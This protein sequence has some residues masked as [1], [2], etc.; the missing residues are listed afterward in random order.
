MDSNEIDRI[1]ASMGLLPLVEPHFAKALEEKQNLEE[2]IDKLPDTDTDT[3]FVEGPSD[4]LLLKTAL[5]LF[6]PEGTRCIN[7][8]CAPKFGGGHSWVADQMIAWAYLR[9]QSRA[10]GLFDQ[11]QCA[12][13]SRKR[14]THTIGNNK[15]QKTYCIHLEPNENVKSIL[16]KIK[17]PFA[18][19]ELFRDT[20]W[21]TAENNGWLTE[22]SDNLPGLYGHND[23]NSSFLDTL[24][25]KFP[26]YP[27]RRIV[28]YKIRGDSKKQFVD[29]LTSL[30]GAEKEEAFQGLKPTIKKIKENFR[31]K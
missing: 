28:W 14:A 19:E 2:K 17:I 7:I 13:E 22:K 20:D 16:Q 29:Y 1:D 4:K 11:D 23:P 12:H 3:V 18:V 10:V 30:Q 5:E 25:E 24:R 27:K 21:N 8:V 9:T 26:E 6:F 31:R 15:R